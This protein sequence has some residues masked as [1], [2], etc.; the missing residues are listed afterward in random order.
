[1]SL[2]RDWDRSAGGTIVLSAN[3]S[4]GKVPFESATRS[5]R[6]NTNFHRFARKERGI[7]PFSAFQSTNRFARKETRKPIYLPTLT[8]VAGYSLKGATPQKWKTCAYSP[9][10][11]P[12][13]HLRKCMRNN[14]GITVETQPP[15]IRGRVFSYSRNEVHFQ[16]NPRNEMWSR[17]TEYFAQTATI[18]EIDSATIGNLFTICTD[19]ILFFETWMPGKLQVFDSVFHL[20]N[21]GKTARQSSGVFSRSKGDIWET[22]SEPQPRYKPEACPMETNRKALD[23]ISS[24]RYTLRLFCSII[25]QLLSSNTSNHRRKIVCQETKKQRR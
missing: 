9:R 20:P 16:K 10:H 23:K 7:P 3:T 4:N 13:F 8:D 24:S 25:I 15:E 21:T 2:L 5:S 12:R 11:F 18:K 1:M 14:F 17:L 6:G 22:T 19:S